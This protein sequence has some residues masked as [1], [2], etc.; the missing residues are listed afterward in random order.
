MMEGHEPTF[1]PPPRAIGRAAF[2][3]LFGGVY[4]SS[5]WVAEAV[6]E[7]GLTAAEDTPEGLHAA[8]RRVVESAPR[9]RQLRLVRAHP[10]LAG[11]AAVAGALTPASTAEQQSA[12]LDRC[13]PEE[14]RRFQEL[15]ARYKERFGFPFVIAVKGLTR[16]EILA[17]FGS[18]IDSDPQ[19]E[20]RAALFQIHKIA[21]LRLQALASG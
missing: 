14:F 4:E 7:A 16:G 1:A 8:M 20:L 2:I 12:G 17:A 11:R 6:W 15:N 9:D 19:S 13:T 5:P 10:D 18:R 3:A 21:R